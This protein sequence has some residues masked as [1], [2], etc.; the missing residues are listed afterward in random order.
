MAENLKKETLIMLITKTNYVSNVTELG[1]NI[2]DN[3]SM[4]TI[5][6][7]RSSDKWVVE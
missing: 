5:V 7:N 6:L 3:I 4:T 1:K 2:T